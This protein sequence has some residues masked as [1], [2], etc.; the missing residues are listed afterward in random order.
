M[1][2]APRALVVGIDRDR[3]AREPWCVREGAA[4][5]AWVFVE[6][7]FARVW[8]DVCCTHLRQQGIV[9]LRWCFQLQLNVHQ[10][11][12][13]LLT[14]AREQSFEQKEGFGFVFVERIALAITP[15]ANRVPQ[16]VEGD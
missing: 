12:G 2:F 14:N 5:V 8:I 10:L 7:V 9:Q 6:L 16:M 15:Q 11:A 4:A 3:A 13:D 1:D